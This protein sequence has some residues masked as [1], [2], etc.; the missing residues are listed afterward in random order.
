VDGS[1][2]I[3]DKII[4][5][6]EGLTTAHHHG[7]MADHLLDV[8]PGNGAR[9][10][11]RMSNNPE[12][13]TWDKD[14]SRAMGYTPKQQEGPKETVYDPELQ[15][16]VG[17]ESAMQHIA[18][19]WDYTKPLEKDHFQLDITPE[20]K[21][22]LEALLEDSAKDSLAY[23]N[24]LY[25]EE[26]VS[27]DFF[28]AA[29]TALKDAKDFLEELRDEGDFA[30]EDHKALTEINELY[31]KMKKIKDDS[32]PLLF[33]PDLDFADAGEEIAEL[34]DLFDDDELEDGILMDEFMS[35]SELEKALLGLQEKK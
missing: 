21:Q 10:L 32:P 27:E 29:Y 9:I 2:N 18:D 17:K 19:E 34:D 22:L 12:A 7:T 20:D 30:E 25:D 16:H 8:S 15:R 24:M 14:L 13:A 11:T 26:F 33:D 6:Q 5:F 4:T 3:S 28:T 35:K 23:K 1:N 31:K